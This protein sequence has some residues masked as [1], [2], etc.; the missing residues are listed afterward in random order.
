MFEILPSHI[1]G[2][3]EINTK[4]H[5]DSRG[6]FVKTFHEDDFKRLGL[7][8]EFKEE[9]YSSS[10]K[11]VVRGMHFQIPPEDHIKLVYCVSGEVFDV[12]VDLRIGSPTYHKVA[13]FNLSEIKGNMIYI[14]KGLAHGFYCTSNEATLLYKT[15]SIHNPAADKGILWSSI[16]A[17]WP[18]YDEPIVSERDQGFPTIDSFISPF[19][20]NSYE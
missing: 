6:K 10:K 12:V 17:D 20:L 15:S 18:V 9:Y 13:S 14:P 8:T 16:P 7:E 2:C 11:N 4:I 3:F 1:D 19:T 5:N